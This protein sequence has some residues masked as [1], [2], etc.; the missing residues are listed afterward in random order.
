MGAATTS[1]EDWPNH[2]QTASPAAG[3]RRGDRPR[4]LSAAR[5]L[6]SL[7]ASGVASAKTPGFR[8]RF[9]PGSL[10]P[11]GLANHQFRLEDNLPVLVCLPA[12][13]L[14]YQQWAADR[15]S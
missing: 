13:R 9:R 2:R 3:L 4:S 14:V 6:L 11:A 8:Q 5:G 7:R 10:G 15:P 1:S 12:E